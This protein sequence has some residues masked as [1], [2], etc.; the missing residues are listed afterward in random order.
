VYLE[1]TLHAVK[2]QQALKY[3]IV[4]IKLII[5]LPHDTNW[6]SWDLKK[7]PWLLHHVMPLVTGIT[8]IGHACYEYHNGKNH[9]F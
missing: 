4:F 6:L 9:N 8:R 5:F 1:S 2:S 3:V 7:G